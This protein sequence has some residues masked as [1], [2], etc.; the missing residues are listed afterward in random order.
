MRKRS[1]TWL[2]YTKVI[3]E[4]VSFDLQIF[5]KELKKSLIRLTILELVALETW[6][7]ERFQA[8]IASKAARIVHEYRVSLY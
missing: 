2:Q 1:I 6:I 4:K 3:L 7:S 8:V 5:L